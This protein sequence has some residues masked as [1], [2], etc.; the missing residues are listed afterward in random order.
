[1]VK[2]SDANDLAYELTNIQ[3]E[4]EA[5]HDKGL[6]QEARS[7]YL[8][9]KAFMYDHVTHHKLI[10]INQSSDSIINESI[11]I[12]RRSMKGILLL[13]CEP[14]TGCARASEKFI[15][16]DI[17]SVKVTNKVYSQE[18]E[19]RDLWDEIYR[20]F[21]ALGATSNMNAT[22][23]YTG[24]KFGL[25]IDLRSMEVTQL[26]GSGLRMVCSSKS[27]EPLRAPAPTS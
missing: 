3:L 26:H 16:P 23:F 1:M 11:N 15:N 27:R 12:P 18:L 6:A 25:F 2:S 22:D 4:Y 17:T 5:L 10:T 20:H 21:G 13:F 14:H 8:N 24:D 7:T 9:G 19:G